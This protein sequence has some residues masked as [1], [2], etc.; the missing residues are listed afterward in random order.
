MEEI[1]EYIERNN[2]EVVFANLKD[3]NGLYI[4]DNDVHIILINKKIKNTEEI[5]CIL[6]EELTH[7]KVGVVPTTAFC[8]DYCQKLQRS[9]NEFKALKSIINELI[10]KE[11]FKKFLE[12]DTTKYEI[13]QEL[14]I[15]EEILEKAY[16]L[17]I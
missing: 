1:Y 3:V 8:G 15:P 14:G 2:I 16:Y 6:I 11:T 5:K 7:Y 17:Y 13:S 4:D 10:P 12:S 9:K